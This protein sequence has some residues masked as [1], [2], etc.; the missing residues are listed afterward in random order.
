MSFAGLSLRSLTPKFGNQLIA[1]RFASTEVTFQTRP[2][3][4]HKLDDGPKAEV[5]LTKEDALD[6]YRKMQV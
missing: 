3:K 4:L 1:G 2:Y 5:T 6:Y